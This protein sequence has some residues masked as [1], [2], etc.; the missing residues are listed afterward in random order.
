MEKMFWYDI[1]FLYKR[2]VKQV[3]EENK[4]AEE[5]NSTAQEQ[6]EEYRNAMRGPDM[7]KM[8]SMPNM[9]QMPSMPS[10]D[11]FMRG[12]QNGSNINFGG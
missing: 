12:M 1:Q 2:Y 3:E 9:P 4:Q 11:S 8:P 5:Q 7:S 10:A 6:A